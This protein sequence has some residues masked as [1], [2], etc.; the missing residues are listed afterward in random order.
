[1]QQFCYQDVHVHINVRSPREIMTAPINMSMFETGIIANG[2]SCLWFAFLITNAADPK[3]GLQC[4][5][6]M[7]IRQVLLNHKD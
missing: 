6:I 7:L 2:R 1:M 4:N 3:Q 5:A